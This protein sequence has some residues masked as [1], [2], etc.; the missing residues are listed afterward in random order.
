MANYNKREQHN[1]L[2]NFEAIHVTGVKHGKTRVKK[3]SVIGFGFAS[4]WFGR[5]NKL[6]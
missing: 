4:D 2:M 1:E 3:S 6:S 5:W